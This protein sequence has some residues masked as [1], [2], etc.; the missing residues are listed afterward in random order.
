[1]KVKRGRQKGDGKK[2]VRK[3]HDKSVPFPSNPILSEGPPAPPIL[4]GLQKGAEKRCRA[5]I[6]EKC[7]KTFWHFLTIFDV[8]CPARKLS[9]SV[10]KLFDAF[11]RFLTWPLSA[12]PFCNPLTFMS[13]EVQKRGKLV[14]EVR[15]P[16]DKTNGRERDALS[17]HFLSRRLPGVP[18]LTFTEKLSIG[19]KLFDRGAFFQSS[20]PAEVR[21]WN[22][23]PFFSAKTVVEFGV[24]EKGKFHANFTLL[25][26]SA[27]LLGGLLIV[28]PGP[29]GTGRSPEDFSH[30]YVPF[31]FL[32]RRSPLTHSWMM[33]GKSKVHS[34]LG[35]IAFL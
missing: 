22:F 2:N 25:R 30:V 3:C 11:W 28:P 27:D 18:F 24:K 26:R 5:K 35:V 23:S 17:W 31:S 32:N 34:F 33:M 1:M 8:F 4:S 13:S 16:K 21:K 15:G 12:G 19:S 10:E 14:R 9:K 20:Y 7:R 29:K 6:V